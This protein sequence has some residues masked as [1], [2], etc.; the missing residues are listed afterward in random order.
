MTFLVTKLLNTALEFI[1]ELFTNM[2]KVFI[3]KPALFTPGKFGTISTTVQMV[4]AVLM[5]LSIMK[6]IVFRLSGIEGN[7]YDMNLGEYM[8][9]IFMN[10]VAIGLF[11]KILVV[12]ISYSTSIYGAISSA[13]GDM[14]S[15]DN[16]DL[17][18][19][20]D[21]TKFSITIL[22]VVIYLLLTGMKSV[23][24]LAKTQIEMLI[25][26]VVFPI[27]LI[28]F[29]KGSDKLNAFMTK[30][31]GL[32]VN[33][34]LQIFLIYFALSNLVEIPLE[35][36]SDFVWKTFVASACFKIS[37]NPAIVADLIVTPGGGARGGGMLQKGYYG[38]RIVSVAR[39]VLT[40]G[41]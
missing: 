38:A 36:S 3:E 10:V 16:L 14:F 32:V 37:A 13:S 19:D 35:I 15:M 18:K 5:V 34:C 22:I 30:F 23:T 4:A 40:K 27:V 29:Y 1:I 2:V 28:D 25:A 17:Y 26:S 39:R 7:I 20:V 11:P 9:K 21:I 12:M 33:M 24:M 31:T 41:V 8:T 6:D